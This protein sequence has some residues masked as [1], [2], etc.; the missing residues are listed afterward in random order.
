MNNLKRDIFS[1]GVVV[2]A[3]ANE[4]GRDRTNN[5]YF[6]NVPLEQ[7][8]LHNGSRKLA[9][10]FSSEVVV[11]DI[12]PTEYHEDATLHESA[13]LEFA[14][15]LENGWFGFAATIDDEKLLD[16]WCRIKM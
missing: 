9:R 16:K 11:T 12:Y 15:H 4:A 8:A 1:G 10:R 6:C 7:P 2:S 3:P 13:E 14:T 5:S